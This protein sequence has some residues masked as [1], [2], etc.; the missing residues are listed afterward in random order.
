LAVKAIATHAFGTSDVLKYV[1]FFKNSNNWNQV[2][3]GGLISAAIA[4]FEAMPERA[5]QVIERSV[6]SNELPMKTYAPDGNYPE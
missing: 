2:C 1:G 6:K 5:K 3:N 4:V